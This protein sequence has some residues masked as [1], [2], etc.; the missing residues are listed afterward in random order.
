[1]TVLWAVC[2]NPTI[3]WTPEH[4]TIWYGV[5]PKR[6]RAILHELAPCGIVQPDGTLSDAIVWNSELDW[7]FPRKVGDRLSVQDQVASLS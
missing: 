6:G 1:M 7:A 3:A 2:A 4:L 5:R